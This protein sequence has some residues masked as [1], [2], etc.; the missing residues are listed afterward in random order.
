MTLTRDRSS[1]ATI[2]SAESK[3]RIELDRADRLVLVLSIGP[4]IANDRR[5]ALDTGANVVHQGAHLAF[6]SGPRS[7]LQQI[8]SE[9]HVLQ[10]IVDL[11]GDPRRHDP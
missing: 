11:V 8:R 10:R 1:W 4:K 6:G 9:H 2:R 5:N 3:M 7:S